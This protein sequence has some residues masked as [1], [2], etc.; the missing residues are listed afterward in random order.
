MTGLWVQQD[1]PDLMR[2]QLRK[3]MPGW[4]QRIVAFLPDKWVPDKGAY[5]TVVSDGTPID[6]GAWTRETVRIVVRSN[7]IN[8]SRRIL[9]E[10]DAYLRTPGLRGFGLGV[11]PGAGIIAMPDSKQGGFMASATYGVTLPKRVKGRT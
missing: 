5:V 1:A 11:R 7:N 9:S 4:E 6:G 2:R 10:I 3:A 8:F